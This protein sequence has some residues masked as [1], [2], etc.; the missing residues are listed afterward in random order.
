MP[1]RP[2]IH[3]P[4]GQL[5]PEEAERRRQ[6]LYN[7]RRPTPKQQGYDGAWRA[8]RKVFL[9]RH[10]ACVWCGQAANEV[11]HIVPVRLDPSRRLDWANL[12]AACTPCHS[13][14]TATTTGFASPR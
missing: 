2:P 13:R 5:P 14:H 6:A 3:R 4:P 7:K 11:D 10:P 9:H 1:Q 12:R 8:L